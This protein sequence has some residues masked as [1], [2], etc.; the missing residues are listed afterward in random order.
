MRESTKEKIDIIF[1]SLEIL[2][3]SFNKNLIFNIDKTILVNRKFSN[4]KF[5]TNKDIN[6]FS[7]KINYLKIY[8]YYLYFS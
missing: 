2:R 1:N 6:V 3:N 4:E 5:I 7:I 8:I